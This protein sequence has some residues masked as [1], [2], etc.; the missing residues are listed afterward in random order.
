M[1]YG[2]KYIFIHFTYQMHDFQL[3]QNPP[4]V[5]LYNFQSILLR[6]TIYIYICAEVGANVKLKDVHYPYEIM[7]KFFEN[8]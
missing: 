1:C 2:E 3:C 5:T 7:L 4:K 6:S 8:S